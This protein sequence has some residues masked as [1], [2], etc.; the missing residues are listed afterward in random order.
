MSSIEI[1]K[2]DL[3]QLITG[4]SVEITPKAALKIANF[5]DWLAEDT[6][7]YVPNLKNSKISD[8]V[9]TCERLQSQGMQAVPHIIVRNYNS[10]NE[11]RQTLDVLVSFGIR[12]ILLLAGAASQPKGPYHSVM[13]LLKTGLLQDYPFNHIGFAGH[14]EG[15]K[16]IPKVEQEAAEAQKQ[17]YALT[18]PHDYYFVT[19]FCFELPP[20]ATW[21]AHL[22]ARHIT[23]PVHIGI[24]GV[25]SL[26][27][28]L[29]HAQACGIGSSMNFLWKNSRN[30]GKLMSL[31]TPDALL[32]NL[33]V[34][35]KTH[36]QT[37][38]QLH[39]YPLGGF[40]TTINWLKSIADGRINLQSK[41][42]T[43]HD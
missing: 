28:L 37:I 43:V 41:G 40:E 4:Y 36:P 39:F 31:N 10:E 35:R 14:P 27:S 20:I 17:G 7:V 21:L 26:Q 11:L 34:Y 24:P 5:R 30:I 3:Q 16:D 18:Y 12:R 6:E 33:A 23:L 42:F 25:A 29:R 15:T 1:S 13:S 22:H 2:E 38:R 19:Q 8:C 32:Y 9:N